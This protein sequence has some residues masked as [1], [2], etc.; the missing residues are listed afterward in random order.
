[1]I[2]SKVDSKLYCPTFVIEQSCGHDVLHRE[3][4][5]VAIARAV[6]EMRVLG[7]LLQVSSRIVLET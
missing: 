2:S 5:D 6:A 1:M 3:K 7:N 4:F